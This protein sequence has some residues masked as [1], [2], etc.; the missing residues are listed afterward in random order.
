MNVKPGAD[1][2]TVRKEKMMR[3]GCYIDSPVGVLQLVEK[4]GA[5]THVLF[6][7][8][9]SPKPPTEKGH[10]VLASVGGKTVYF[11]EAKTP[12]LAEV[13]RQLTEYFHGERTVFDIPL[14]P[15]GTPFQL[16][17]WEGLQTI[18]YGETRTYKQMAEYAGSPRGYRAIGLANNRNPISIIVPC[19]R[20]IGS[21]GKLV[22][23][24][25]GLDTKQLLLDLE[26]I[27]LGQ[28]GNE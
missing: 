8:R 22:G 18:P 20:V 15:E 21:D 27:T 17:A 3:Y 14:A 26:K 1:A 4:D 10:E 13:E 12:L 9:R 24:G 23:F 7:S 5:L 2:H 6:C 25:G 16:K 19:H 11:E 28:G